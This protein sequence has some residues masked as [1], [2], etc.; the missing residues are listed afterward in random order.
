MRRIIFGTV[1]LVACV[2]VLAGSAVASPPLKTP[3]NI[4]INRE[5]S[6]ICAFPIRIQGTQTGHQ[7]DFFD[8]DGQL[9]RR[10]RHGVERVTFT[11][12]GQMPVTTEKCRFMTIE[13]CRSEAALR[14]LADLS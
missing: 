14:A 9:V 8:A 7:I 10:H 6:G 5:V 12:N 4:T 1:T 13:T 2:F 11:A 3:L